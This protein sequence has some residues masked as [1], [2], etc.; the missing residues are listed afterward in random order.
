MIPCLLIAGL[1]N[2]QKESIYLVPFNEAGG[3]VK[4]DF[5]THPLSFINKRGDKNRQF[6][7]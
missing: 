7:Y 1:S 5:L 6:F 2:L 4:T 3:S